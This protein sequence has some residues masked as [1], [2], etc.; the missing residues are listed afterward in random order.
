MAWGGVGRKETKKK[1]VKG[2]KERGSLK[3][4]NKKSHH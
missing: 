1:R 2:R 3:I 4:I